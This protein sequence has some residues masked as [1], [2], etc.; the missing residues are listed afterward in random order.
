MNN[1][2][3]SEDTPN[4]ELNDHYWQYWG[5]IRSKELQWVLPIYKACA[6]AL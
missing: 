3:C 5:I 1:R 4:N 2:R 6:L